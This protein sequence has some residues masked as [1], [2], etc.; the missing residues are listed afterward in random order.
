M[1]TG[2]FFLVSP[3]NIEPLSY[4]SIIFPFLSDIIACTIGGPSMGLWSRS[5]KPQVRAWM[6]CCLMNNDTF[7]TKKKLQKNNN[8]R[9]MKYVSVHNLCYSNIKRSKWEKS[10]WKRVLKNEKLVQFF[11]V[12]SQI[13]PMMVITKRCSSCSIRRGWLRKFIHRCWIY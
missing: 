2:F 9:A 6:G 11:F 12:D 5:P 13:F 8:N 4:P 1:T 7:L 3:W 10:E